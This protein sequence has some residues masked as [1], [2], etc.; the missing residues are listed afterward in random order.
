MGSKQFWLALPLAIMA[1]IVALLLLWRPLEQLSQGAPPVE[2]AAIERVQLTPGLI[3]LD[4]RTDGSAPVVIAQLQVDTAYRE[5][6]VFPATAT[7]R[8]GRIRIDIPYPWIEGEAH[9]IALITATGGVVAELASFGAPPCRATRGP[10]GYAPSVNHGRHA[11]DKFG[12][13]CQVCTAAH[14]DRHRALRWLKDPSRSAWTADGWAE[15]W[16]V[17]AR[18]CSCSTAAR[19]STGRISSP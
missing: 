17:A 5:F 3:S 7:A 1:A 12:C 6:T 9:H 15:R 11:H 19:A 16:W 18:P 10:P 13:R 4:V 8:L 14:S 2:E